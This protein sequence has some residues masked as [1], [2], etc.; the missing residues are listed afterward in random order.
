MP[1]FKHYCG[2]PVFF[3]LIITWLLLPMICLAQ[4]Q[5]RP[6]KSSFFKNL[7]VGSKFYYGS[8]LTTKTKAE[9][10]RDSYA[11]FGEIFIQS[12]TDG[13]KDWQLSHRYPQWGV[14]F[15]FGNTGSRQYIGRLNALYAYV[16][17][18][19][20]VSRN[21][22]GSFL[23]GAGP[24]WISK[25]FDINTNPKNTLIGTRL[26]AFINL[27]LQNEIRLSKHFFLTGGLSFLHLSNGGTTLPNLGLNTPC[28]SV[29]ARYAF[30]EPVKQER[31]PEQFIKKMEY[32]VYTS[33]GLKQAPWTG[34]NHYLINNIQLEA[35]KRVKRNYSY[36]L[37]LQLSY[38]RSL[39]YFPLENPDREKRGRKKLQAGVYVSYE[40]FLGKLS[41]PLQLGAYVYNK[42][43]SPV[44]FQQFGLRYQCTKHISTEVLLKSHMGQADFIHLGIGYNL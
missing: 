10:I 9:Y 8:F 22:N 44:L 38:N 42:A 3:L 5:S 14:S 33:V 20:V 31:T 30:A 16:N 17:L 19:L 32:Y 23:L 28:F 4:D 11:S 37:G 39:D 2:R 34:G 35:A 6:D 27:G 13:S 25:P 24:G 26:N 43:M 21:Y 29:G 7:S 15:L 18:P 41:L 12:Q 40:H 36:G 1:M